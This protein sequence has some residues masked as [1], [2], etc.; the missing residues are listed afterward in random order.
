[1]EAQLE[2]RDSQI[3]EL[4]RLYKQSRDAE[5]RLQLLGPN[6]EGMI[7]ADTAPSIHDMIQQENGDLRDRIDKLESRLRFVL[8]S[9][10]FLRTYLV[11]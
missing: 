8:P 11:R 9:S 4:K 6:N 5:L 1:M 3:H 7:A 2:V 10:T